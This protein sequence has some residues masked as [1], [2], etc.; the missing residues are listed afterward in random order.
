MIEF[1]HE[2][3]GLSNCRLREK[4]TSWSRD[5]KVGGLES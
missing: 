1:L 3:L 2:W 5:M 4:H